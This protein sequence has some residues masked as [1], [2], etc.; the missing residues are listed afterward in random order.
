MR[1]FLDHENAFNIIGAILIGVPLTAGGIVA[2]TTPSDE[3][4]DKR[5]AEQAKEN[6][7]VISPRPGVECYILRS[8]SGHDPRVMSCIGNVPATIGQ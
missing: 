6:I 1:S 4:L 7:V 2:C 3:E 5:Y 8:Q